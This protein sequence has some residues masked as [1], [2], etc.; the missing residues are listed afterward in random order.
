MIWKDMDDRSSY[1]WL[2]EQSSG[3]WVAYIL[4]SPLVSRLMDCPVE[5]GSGILISK[6]FS[7]IK[8]AKESVFFELNILQL[9]H[10]TDFK[11]GGV[12]GL[13]S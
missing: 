6:E 8:P 1:L 3:R 12:A 9:V 11:T 4:E 7:H 2:Y 5:K 10:S 13:G